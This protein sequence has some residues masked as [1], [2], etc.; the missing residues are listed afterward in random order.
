MQ[1]LNLSASQKRLA[2]EILDLNPG[3]VILQPNAELRPDVGI[4]NMAKIYHVDCGDIAFYYAHVP[5]PGERLTAQSSRLVDGSRPD[6]GMPIV[7]GSCKH[8]VSLECLTT[9]NP[10][11]K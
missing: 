3:A 7:C 8:R 5:V 2:E 9:I 4:R 6:S 11:A 10:K 1:D